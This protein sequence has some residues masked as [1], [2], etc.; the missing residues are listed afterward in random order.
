MWTRGCEEA[1]R[2]A[3]SSAGRAVG[4]K[5]VSAADWKD[6]APA[7]ER[8]ASSAA[9]TAVERVA[10]SADLSVLDSEWTMVGKW[11]FGGASQ[12]DLTVVDER[13]GATGAGTDALSAAVSV[14]LEVASKELVAVYSTAVYWENRSAAVKVS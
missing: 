7:A 13:A 6:P 8:A 9:W 4:W 11:D 10:S 14:A 1:V 2:W 3:A 5:A 12:W